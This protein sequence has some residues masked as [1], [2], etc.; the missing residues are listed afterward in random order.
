MRTV[1]PAQLWRRFCAWR[2]RTNWSLCCSHPDGHAAAVP[3]AAASVTSGDHSVDFR[4]GDHRG[5]VRRP[6]P[7]AGDA[8]ATADRY[9]HRAGAM[10]PVA[11]GAGTPAGQSALHRHAHLYVVYANTVCY[12]MCYMM[13][14]VRRSVRVETGPLCACRGWHLSRM[15]PECVCVQRMA[16]ECKGGAVFS[17]S[18]AA[19]A[20]PGPCEGKAWGGG[21][22]GKVC[23]AGRAG[24]AAGEEGMP[25]WQQARRAC[26]FGSRRAGHAGLAAGEE[27]MR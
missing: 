8:S 21:S 17:L 27:G 12:S 10:A 25:V 20:Q 23:S 7:C 15:A 19:S 13:Q 11:A 3:A 18:T 24:L 14:Q 26:G 1:A 16:P 6:C 2:S 22:R 5:A 4:L 9:P